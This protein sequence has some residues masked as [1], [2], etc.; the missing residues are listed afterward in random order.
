MRKSGRKSPM[1]LASRPWASD[2]NCHELGVFGFEPKKHVDDILGAV[3][4]PPVE[5]L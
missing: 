4:G 2:W 5:M 1:S 3:L